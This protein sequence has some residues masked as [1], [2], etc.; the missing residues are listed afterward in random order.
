MM[1][2][3]S[4]LKVVPATTHIPLKDVPNRLSI[5]CLAETIKITNEAM[6]EKFDI[7]EGKL[8]GTKLKKIEEKWINNDFKVSEKEIFQVVK[9]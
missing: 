2:A 5:K 1:L 9:S 3:C 8:L 6:K 7:S 4:K